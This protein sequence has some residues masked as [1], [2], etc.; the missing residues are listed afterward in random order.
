[1]CGSVEEAGDASTHRGLTRRRL[2]GGAAAALGAWSFGGCGG[3]HGRRLEELDPRVPALLASATSVDF[4]SHAAGAGNARVP[5]FDLAD[6][7]RRGHLSA[8]CLCHS[9]DGPVIRRPVGG[10]RIRQYRDPAPGELQAHTERRLAFMDALV[11][12]HGMT[13]VLTPGELYAHTQRRLAFMDALVS[14]HGMTRVL[15]PADLD[16]AKAAG[17]PALIGTIEGC[18]FM[19]GRLERVQEVYDRGI[20]HLQIVHYMPSDLGDQQT[21][22]AKWGGLS[23]LGADVIRECNRLGIVVDVA[24]STYALVK[25]AA[26]LSVTPLVLSH[27]SLTRGPLRPYSRLISVEHARLMA[28]VGG[29]IGV[30]PS[31]F[32][33]VDGRD[34]VAGIARMVDAAGVDHVGIGTDMEGGVNEVWDDYADLP[35]VADLLLRQGFSPAEASKILGGNYVRVFRQ[36]AAA[37]RAARGARTLAR[38]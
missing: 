34:W 23:P 4:H 20:R 35:A 14:Q 9:A 12:Q 21:E 16:A 25:Q 6:H 36:V 33:F 22:D 38:R 27:T 8:V 32:S 11:A 28:E 5:R 31:G 1:M 24:H 18:Q 3:I 29:V 26:T 13:R 37:R 30:W 7:M 10:G 17:R 19:D 2:L 15:T